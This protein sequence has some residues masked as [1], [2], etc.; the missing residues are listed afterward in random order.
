MLMASSNCSFGP[1]LGELHP[2]GIAAGGGD[3]VEVQHARRLLGAQPHDVLEMRQLVRLH[4]IVDDLEVVRGLERRRQDQRLALDLVHRVLELGAPVGRVDVDQHQPR[5]GGGELGQGPFRAVGR[6][7]ADPVA[8]LQPQRHQAG[9]EIVDA[10]AEL[11]PAPA[12]VLVAHHQRLAVAVG[13]DRAVEEGADGLADQLLVGDAVVVGDLGH[14][15]DISGRPAAP[16]LISREGRPGKPLG[17][18]P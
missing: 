7:D 18:A 2:L 5:L 3:I 16:Q 12:H 13:L 15:R 11:A 1:E 8:A 6:P 17:S 10:A 9:R 4:E 14:A